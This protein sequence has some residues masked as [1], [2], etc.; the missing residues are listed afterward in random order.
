MQ[1][2]NI[3]NLKKSYR[4]NIVLD[5]INLEIQEGELF[6]L[7]G[8]SGSGKSSLL[9]CIAGLDKP[10]KGGINF[11]TKDVTDL[12]AH[13]REAAMVFQSFALWPHMSVGENVAFGLE[14]QGVRGNELV[15]RVLE[16]LEDVQLKGFED[17]DIDT[18]S[19][20]E[21]QR[22]ALARALVVRPKCLLLD[23]PLSN[24]DTMLRIEMRTEIRRIVKEHG[25]TAIY[26]THDHEEAMAIA[27]KIAIMD[28]GKVVQVGTPEDVYRFPQTRAAA[29]FMGSVNLFKARVQDIISNYENNYIVRAITE[30]G[31]IFQGR[32][33]SLT[34]KP[35]IEDNV[36][37]CIRP[38][39]L[40]FDKSGNVINQIGGIVVAR[41][42][43]GSTME[44]MIRREDGSYIFV[45]QMNPRQVFEPGENVNLNAETADVIILNGMEKEE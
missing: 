4:N 14:E 34:I 12:S 43:Q 42:Y 27:D 37:V 20:G 32:A 23:E 38:Q 3:K 30:E 18:L 15:K 8:S 13:K 24:L 35:D 1:A 5:N 6:F 41:V 22:V 10:D 9:R 29:S 33:T 25:L 17:R 11:G 31:Y 44:Y 40:Y 28:K 39:A 21:Q 2:I 45:T 16:A 26:V 7:V 36:F 19:G